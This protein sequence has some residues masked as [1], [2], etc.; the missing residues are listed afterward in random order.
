MPDSKALRKKVNRIIVSS[1]LIVRNLKCRSRM[2]TYVLRLQTII[3]VIIESI[4]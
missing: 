1:S 2:L 3:N 4:I